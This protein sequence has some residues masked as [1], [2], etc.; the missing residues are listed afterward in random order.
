MIRFL[1]LAVLITFLA[2]VPASSP[3]QSY[4]EQVAEGYR[5]YAARRAPEALEHYLAALAADSLNSTRSLV[6]REWKRISPS[7]TPIRRTGARCWRARSGTGAPSCPGYRKTPKPTS[8][9]SLSTTRAQRARVVDR[10]HVP[11]LRSSL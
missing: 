8:P 3:A 10:L 2:A 7:S 9:A 4:A 6:P 11:S 5:A 1:V